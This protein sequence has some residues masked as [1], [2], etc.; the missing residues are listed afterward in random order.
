MGTTSAWFGVPGHEEEYESLL[1]CVF[2]YRTDYDSNDWQ[3]LIKIAD[4]PIPLR[5]EILLPT[6]GVFEGMYRWFGIRI[7]I[8]EA[9]EADDDKTVTWLCPRFVVA[10]LI[11]TTK[12]EDLKEILRTWD[13]KFSLGVFFTYTTD[14]KVYIVRYMTNQPMSFFEDKNFRELYSASSVRRARDYA[15]QAVTVCHRLMRDPAFHVNFVS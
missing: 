5:S 10:K 8:P 3:N 12:N 2:R 13:P 6:G 7:G 15:P 11:E 4:L 9:L 1:N 14:S